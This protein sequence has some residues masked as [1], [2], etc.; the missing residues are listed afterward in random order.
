MENYGVSPSDNY[1]EHYV[2]M[3]P[4]NQS[5]RQPCE[6]IMRTDG[7][8]TFQQHLNISTFA[9]NKKRHLNSLKKKGQNTSMWRG[10]VRLLLPVPFRYNNV[11]PFWSNVR[12]NDSIYGI[13]VLWR[14]VIPHLN[15]VDNSK[16]KLKSE[17]EM[18]NMITI[19]FLKRTK[20]YII[21]QIK[22][23]YLLFIKI[24]SIQIIK[25]NLQY[26]LGASFIDVLKI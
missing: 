19:E 15:S 10:G 11:S 13:F 2:E 26:N 7:P 6:T 17:I 16:V 23:N 4:V 1:V 18:W 14:A 5:R 20:I 25:S 3:V 22:N 21:F 8:W 24:Y 9:G 12:E